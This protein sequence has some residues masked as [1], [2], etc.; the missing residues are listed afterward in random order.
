MFSSTHL[1]TLFISIKLSCSFYCNGWFRL[2]MFFS[3][4]KSLVRSILHFEHVP[5]LCLVVIRKHSEIIQMMLLHQGIEFWSC[6]QFPMSFYQYISKTLTCIK[7]SIC[8]FCSCRYF[9]FI[10][11]VIAHSYLGCP[12]PSS[13]YFGS[14]AWVVDQRG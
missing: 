10:S 13:Q 3:H 4:F 6:F 14:F 7:H 2:I 12:L 5:G 11:H 8:S 9:W 1:G